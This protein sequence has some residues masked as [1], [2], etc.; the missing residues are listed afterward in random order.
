MTTSVQDADPETAGFRL[1]KGTGTL[2]ASQ[3]R[4]GADV[5]DHE[6][7]LRVKLTPPD[8]TAE[9]E[10]YGRFDVRLA[11]GTRRARDEAVQAPSGVVRVIV[12]HFVSDFAAQ[13][14]AG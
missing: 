13:L 11:F 3:M 9:A 7:I 4:G 14:E 12:E 6:P 8:P 2:N 1:T 5:N 10:W